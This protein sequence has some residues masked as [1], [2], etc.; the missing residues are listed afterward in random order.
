MDDAALY[1][2]VA[3]RDRRFQGR[4][5]V[6]V[7]STR[8]YCRPGCP[9]P[10]P[11]R[12]N[13]RFF[14]HAAAAEAAGFRPCLRCRPDAGPQA[15]PDTSQTVRRALRLIDG[16]EDDVGRLAARLG[17]GAR[18]LRR[19][20]A[21]QVGASP[22]QVVRTRRTHLARKLLEETALS[23]TEVAHA[24]GYGSLRRFQ[25][26]I[27]ATFRRPAT[28]LR[29][30]PS[31]GETVV[32][33]LPYKPPYDWAGVLAFLGAR[34]VP[35]VESVE[36]GVYRRVVRGGT[37]AVADG[38][39]H[40]RVTLPLAL[41]PRLAEVIAR[42]SRL[43]DLR[44]DP[45]AIGAHLRRS[46]RLRALVAARPG[47]RVPGAFDGFE[48]AARAVLGQRVSVK[49]ARTLAARLCAAVGGGAFPGPGEV[50]AV[51]AAGLRAI[52]LTAARARALE[53]LAA[54]GVDLE[55]GGPE[56]LAALAELPGFGPWTV[57]YVAMR[58]L[59]EPDAWPEGDL[60]LERA[61]AGASPEPFRPFRAY[62]AM[63]LWMEQS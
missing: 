45:A 13:V 62:A 54:S 9:A 53:A 51:G 15:L 28:A 46:P 59:G 56:A 52:G 43:F 60:V 6:A 50:R 1:E 22:A 31:Q 10:V 19:L 36:D 34:A 27:R 12:G 39:A 18:H 37:I 63:H 8:V 17:L 57:G 49:A 14:Q 35:G 23:V 24:A 4:F 47:L 7:T 16:G 11:K 55:G 25:A 5:V 21:E 42:L 26:E 44:A 41:A 29:R 32:L 48:L 2:A 30:A 58:A 33:R 20:F 61:L 40:L 38:E 3:S